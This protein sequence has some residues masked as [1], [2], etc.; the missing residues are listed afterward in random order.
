MDFRQRLTT[1]ARRTPIDHIR[2]RNIFKGCGGGEEGE[3]GGGGIMSEIAIDQ[4]NLPGW[5]DKVLNIE[6]GL[7]LDSRPHTIH[8]SIEI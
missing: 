4:I 8:S 1:K 3:G 6:I 5:N 2:Y 7:K